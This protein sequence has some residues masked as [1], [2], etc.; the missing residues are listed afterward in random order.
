MSVQ[1]NEEAKSFS[2]LDQNAFDPN[3]VSSNPRLKAEVERRQNLVGPMSVLFYKE[4]LDI[5]EAKGVWIYDVDGKAY[6]DVYN[7]VQSIGHCNESV[8]E[9]ITAQL[10]SVNCHN[11]YL[12]KSL[13]DYTQRLLATMPS[14]IDRMMMTCTG[15][16]SN[17]LAIRCARKVSGKQGVIVSKMAYHGNTDLVSQV[18]P[19]AMRYKQKV[20]WVETI[21][22]VAVLNAD[23]P[24]KAFK[25]AIAEAVEALEK[26][27]FG[28]AAFLADTIFSSDGVYSDPLGFMAS[29]IEYLR[30]KGGLY[31]ADE[32]QPGFGRTGA[33]WGFEKQGLVPDIVTMGKPMGN[34]YPAAAIATS[35]RN[36]EIVNHDQGYFNTFGGSHGAVAAATAVLDF[37][38]GEN[39]LDNV[40]E[41]SA[42]LKKSFEEKIATYP[43]VGDIRTCGFFSGVDIVNPDQISDPLF[44]SKLVNTLK[45]NGVLVGTTGYNGSSLKL[46][47]QLIFTKENVDFLVEKLSLSIEQVM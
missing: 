13:H 26:S 29:G 43:I 31:I 19:S 22:I 34:G 24:S 16:E 38:E 1:C 45:E 25:D 47:P 12:S 40:N 14:S 30:S 15:S 41:V 2:I 46:R 36:F 18:S 42:Y 37:I 7:N 23:D 5:A 3:T 44:T 39:I 8:V 28:C 33:M 9:A 27:G 6:L 21:D 32:V 4:P 35:A 10:S 11:R 20:E 17:D